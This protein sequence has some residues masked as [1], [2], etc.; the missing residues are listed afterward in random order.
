[1]AYHLMNM[2]YEKNFE[3]IYFTFFCISFSCLD[4]PNKI[5]KIDFDRFYKIDL[6]SIILM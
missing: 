5:M 2:S 4:K 1:M 6:S 3:S